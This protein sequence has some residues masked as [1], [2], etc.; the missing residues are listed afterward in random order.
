MGFAFF[1]ECPALLHFMAFATVTTYRKSVLGIMAG[2]AGRTFFHLI[3]S[4]VFYTGF[5]WKQLC[6]AVGTFVHA[7]MEFMAECCIS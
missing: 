7:Q 2:T 3:H 6:M 5:V 4:E 1:K